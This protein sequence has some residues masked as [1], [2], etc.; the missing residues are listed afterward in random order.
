MPG[1]FFP[2]TTSKE[3]CRLRSRH[4]SW[5]VRYART[6]MHGGNA[7]PRR[8]GKRSQHF[9]RMRNVMWRYLGLVWYVR[10]RTTQGGTW[11][12]D[13]SCTML[14]R[15][16][17]YRPRSETTLFSIYVPKS[18]PAGWPTHGVAASCMLGR[19]EGL[20]YRQSTTNKENRNFTY[21]TR[22][23]RGHV[24]TSSNDTI[25][26]QRQSATRCN[27]DDAA[28]FYDVELSRIHS[29]ITKPFF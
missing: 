22:G 14:Q 19:W 25:R 29:A 4:A 15:W 27:V 18:E 11:T 7:N 17:I 8:L 13:M 21:L 26:I 3:T 24:S 2:P 9:L 6:L 10:S 5:H 12:V 1:T 20:V 28:L 16:G 23:P